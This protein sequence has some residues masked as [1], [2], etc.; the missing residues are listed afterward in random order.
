[1]CHLLSECEF[2]FSFHLN[3]MPKLDEI[4]LLNICVSVNRYHYSRLSES[5]KSGWLKL[6]QKLKEVQKL[7][8]RT[9]ELIYC[10]LNH[11]CLFC[12]LFGRCDACSPY[13][14]FSPSGWFGQPSTS[15]PTSH[16]ICICGNTNIYSTNTYRSEE[17]GRQQTNWRSKCASRKWTGPSTGAAKRQCKWRKTNSHAVKG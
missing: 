11:S 17:R 14:F 15:I 4:F 16:N 9:G 7:F 3:H 13:S 6:S 12:N 8:C 2:A 1:M 10:Y 5:W